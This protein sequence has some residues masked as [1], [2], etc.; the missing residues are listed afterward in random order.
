MKKCIFCNC[1][2]SEIVAENKL[3]FAIMD[4]FPVNKGH[5]LIQH[6]K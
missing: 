1:N 3:A 2:P 5:T 6:Y 4:K